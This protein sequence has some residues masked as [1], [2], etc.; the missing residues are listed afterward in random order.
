[1]IQVLIQIIITIAK[2]M[3]VIVKIWENKC[4]DKKLYL[5]TLKKKLEEKWRWCYFKK[6]GNTYSWYK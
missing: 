1:M 6:N 3:S 5:F 4:C 2:F